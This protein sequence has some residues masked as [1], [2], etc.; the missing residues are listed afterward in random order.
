VD[1]VPRRS[2]QP[3]R[4]HV[5]RRRQRR[6]P[7]ASVIRSSGCASLVRKYISR[8]HIKGRRRRRA[9]D[10]PARRRP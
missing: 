7:C 2:R 1:A 6:V 9:A 5:L 10:V 8:V 3:A 4:A